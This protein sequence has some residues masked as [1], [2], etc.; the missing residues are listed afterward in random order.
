MSVIAK[1][2]RERAAKADGA[3]PAPQVE[4][5][6]LSPMDRAVRPRRFTPARIGAAVVMALVLAIAIFAYVR[7]GMQRSLSVSADRVTLSAV[8]QA[9]FSDYAPVSG[10]VAPEDT[11]FL[12]TVEGGQVTEVLVEDG[13]SVE[14]G[15]PLARLKNTRLELEV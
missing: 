10:A 6:A 7:Y 1:F 11:V 8:E 5:P 3:P 9:P 14:A 4:A 2:R 15:Q 12:D 13:A